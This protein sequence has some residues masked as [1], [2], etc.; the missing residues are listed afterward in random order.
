[1]K[2]IKILLIL[3]FPAM[4]FGQGDTT[5]KDS[6]TNEYL[7][8]NYQS[9]KKYVIG[10]IGIY[11]VKFLDERILAA[12]TGLYEG[13]RITIPG[14]EITKAIDNLW[15][16]K[17]FVNVQVRLKKIEEDKVF[18]D[19][20]LEER[21]RLD[22]IQIR[23]LK[24]RHAK[25]LRE[26]LSLQTGQIVTENVV[27]RTRNEVLK[28]FRE[29][30]YFNAKV[31]ITEVPSDKRRNFVNLQIAVTRGQ[32]VKINDVIFVGNNNVSSAK[33]RRL[34][35]DT[36]R[37]AW[38]RLFKRSKFIEDVYDEEKR[39]IIGFYN[40]LGYRDAI[41]VSDTFYRH[42]DK[43]VNVQIT[44]NEGSKYYFRHIT[45]AGNTKFTSDTLGKLL[46]IKRGDVY[47][48]AALESK[49]Y[50][51]PAG[52]DISALYMDDGYLFFQVIPVE[53]NVEND[54]IDLEIRI[55]EGPQATIS[56]VTVTGNSKTSDH[57]ILRELR[58]RPGQKFSRTAIQRSIRELVA[59]GYFDPEKMDVQPKPN[60]ASGTV[61]IEYKVEERSSDQ[62]ELSG[63]FGQGFLVGTLGLSLSNFATRKMFKKGGWDP[64]PSG[65]G[66]RLSIRAQ[67]NGRYFQSYNFSFTEPWFG[68]RRPNSL[69]FSAYH[70][71][72]NYGTNDNPSK[73]KI[74]GVSLG[75]G[76][77]LRWPDDWFSVNYSLNYQYYD[78]KNF[79]SGI[80]EFTNGWANNVNFRALFSRNSTDDFIFPQSG[81][82]FNFSAQLTPPIS[83]FTGIDYKNATQQEKFKWIEY[84][85]WKFDAFHYTK[86]AKN[87]VLAS[88]IRTGFMGF[89]NR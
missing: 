25:N 39:T 26:E 81:S 23:K 67:S 65:D 43:S 79:N 22:E 54:S 7:D 16:Q 52:Y 21:P 64:Y 12:L 28:H 9:P 62:I 6:L 45:W 8:L 20:Y 82:Q 40:T 10:G 55:Q 27:Q 44:I 87:L 85:K 36:K 41:M 24:K 13:K 80:F 14:D 31:E 11:G 56:S 68:G 46:D 42:D 1:M 75:L 47:N 19:F 50:M 77:R 72:Q 51:N 57:V 63:G 18:I 69:S 59:L 35:S 15:K 61:D 76:K 83:A 58:T 74:T 32:R 84:H 29:K 60:P 73:L 33:L 78:L 34:M 37:K 71:I 66:Q 49:L 2:Y 86:L 5:Q 17:F 30:G 3:M 89:Y 53:I 70:S 48:V 88:M 4:L 38:W